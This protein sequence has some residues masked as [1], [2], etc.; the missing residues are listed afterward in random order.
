MTQFIDNQ[1]DTITDSISGLT[2]LKKDSRQVTGKWMHLEK[3]RKFAEEQSGSQVGGF[4]DWR[5]PT[6]ED[7]KT[8]YNKEFSNRDFGNNEIF[9]PEE[10]EKGCADCTWTDTVN[11]ERAMM[12]SLVKGR[13]SWINKFG[14]GP[15]AVRL[16]RGERKS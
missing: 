5:V 1:N 4:N 2:W 16:V 12:F 13:S 6:L 10:F 9:I 14:E 3:A 11:G 15:F 8:I 7:V